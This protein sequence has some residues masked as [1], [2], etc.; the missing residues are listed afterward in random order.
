MSIFQPYIEVFTMLKLIISLVHNFDTLEGDVEGVVREVAHNP[1][2]IS[3]LRGAVGALRKLADD[4]ERAMS[5][6]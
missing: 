4:L 5:E 6:G 3:K 1:D 2:A